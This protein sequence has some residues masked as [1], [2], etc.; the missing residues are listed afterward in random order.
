MS[1]KDKGFKYTLTIMYKP[2]ED[3]CEFIQ[4]ELIDETDDDTSWKYGDLDLKDY[5]SDS[6][7]AGLT[8]CEIG[9]A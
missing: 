4:E 9:K 2:G 1:K 7:I 5:F 8:C 6:D 3:Q